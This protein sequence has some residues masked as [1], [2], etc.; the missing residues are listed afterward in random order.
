[1]TVADRLAYAPRSIPC[2]I[3]VWLKNNAADQGRPETFIVSENA[4][5]FIPW[6]A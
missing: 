4:L 6:P 3:A 2:V 5:T 1:M